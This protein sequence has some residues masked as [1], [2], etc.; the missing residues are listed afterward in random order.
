MS[1]TALLY[2]ANV[3]AI[4]ILTLGLYFPRH[5]RRDL[6][7]AYLGVNLGI[8]AVSSVLLSTAAARAWASGSSAS[9]R[10]SDYGPTN[11]PNTRSPT[12][13]PRWL[14]AC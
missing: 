9:C 13:S 6:V 4:A 1:T 10:S 12:T 14:S 3:A 8:M 7:V 2:L 5:G 11:S